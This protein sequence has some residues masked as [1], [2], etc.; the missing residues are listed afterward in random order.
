[1]IRV[2]WRKHVASWLVCSFLFL[3]VQGTVAADSLMQAISGIPDLM[4]LPLTDIYIRI[5][6]TDMI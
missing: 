4:L 1:M 5:P 3:T 2:K 6:L